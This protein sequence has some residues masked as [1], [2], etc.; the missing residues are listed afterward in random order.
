M[1]EVKSPFEG[2]LGRFRSWSSQDWPV[3]LIRVNLRMCGAGNSLSSTMAYRPQQA[4]PSW[5]PVEG[6]LLRVPNPL[7]SAF[8]VTMSG[9]RFLCLRKRWAKAWHSKRTLGRDMEKT[10]NLGP[11]K[12][13]NGSCTMEHPWAM[14]LSFRPRTLEEVEQALESLA[15]CPPGV[16]DPQVG[17]KGMRSETS[18]WQARGPW[19]A[20]CGREADCRHRR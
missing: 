11:R 15:A 13:V 5:K 12:Q 1:R 4:S 2:R 19:E 7:A 18:G 14:G 10:S 17:R 3:F 20:R 9:H 8:A 16:R 6:S